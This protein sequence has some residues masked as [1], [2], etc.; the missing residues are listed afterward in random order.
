M[1]EALS[2]R[3]EEMAAGMRSH[4]KSDRASKVDGVVRNGCCVVSDKKE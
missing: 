3:F 2:G 4:K 1:L